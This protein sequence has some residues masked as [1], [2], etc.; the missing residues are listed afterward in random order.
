[1]TVSPTT[2]KP[3]RFI[4][5]DPVTKQKIASAE[6]RILSLDLIRTDSA[7][8]RDVSQDWVQRHLPFDPK[9]AGAIVVSARAGNLYCVDGGHRVA[10][11]RA[12]GF[13]QINAMVVDGLSQ[14]QEAKHFTLYQRER[15]NLKSFDLYRADLVSGDP[16]VLAI[17]RI[18][19]N[20]GFQ[21]AKVTGTRNITA[22]ESLKWIYRFGSDDLLTR[23]LDYIRR[24]WVEE[25]LALNGQVLKGMAIFLAD[26]GNQPQFSRERFEVVMNRFSAAKILRFA[27]AIAER[28]QRY[29]GNQPTDIALAL[30]E[31]YNKLSGKDQLPPLKMAGKSIPKR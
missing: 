19:H 24:L 16:D 31:Q 26:A 12:S 17:V 18:V 27:Q 20:A 9:Q 10:L 13:G 7:Y 3:K 1:M 11:A 4:V 2:E 8:Q 22:I 5:R 30:Q 6:L 15:R 28:K 23:T 21:I 29:G 25:A 14:A